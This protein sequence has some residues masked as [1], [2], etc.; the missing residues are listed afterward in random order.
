[1]A[2]P[3]A[4]VTYFVFVLLCEAHILAGVALTTMTVLAKAKSQQSSDVGTRT[5]PFH[6]QAG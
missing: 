2:H 6:G 5:M 4:H 1:L 3:L